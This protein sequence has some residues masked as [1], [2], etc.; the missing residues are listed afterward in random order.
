MSQQMYNDPRTDARRFGWRDTR[1]KDQKL[2][3]IAISLIMTGW[4]CRFILNQ[5]RFQE[6]PP[7][8]RT[9]AGASLSTRVNR[10]Q[11][12]HCTFAM[13][14]GIPLLEGRSR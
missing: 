13:I 12:I 6:C 10:P 8:S 9:L 7:P 3:I 11:H 1:A 5:L 4:I 2:V 14:Y